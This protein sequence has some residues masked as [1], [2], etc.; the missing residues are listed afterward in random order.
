MCRNIL[1]AVEKGD[2]QA[3]EAALEADPGRSAAG[4]E[5][6][7]SVLLQAAY[8]GRSD[9]VEVLLRHRPSLDIFE[10]AALGRADRVEELLREDT[11][12]AGAWSADGFTALHLAAF[13]RH[14]DCARLLIQQGADV[15]AHS[16]NPM[17]VAPLN[18]AAASGQREVV[19]MLLD[20]GAEVNACQSG[21]YTSLH[22]AAHNGDGPLVELLLSRGA[23]TGLKTDEGK[24]AADMA[25]EKDHE[26]LAE[27]LDST[28]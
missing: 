25:R 2:M 17:S 3:L 13:F 16:H 6:G 24:S 1:E 11:S 10:A 22:S 8:R 19:E 7:V 5:G 4:D 23:S 28:R 21:G 9:M 18:S 26:E 27:R 15:S 12:L 14:I 20:H